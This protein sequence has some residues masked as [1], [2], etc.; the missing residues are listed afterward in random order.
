MLT[1]ALAQLS[2]GRESPREQEFGPT[3]YFM[4]C[5]VD[6]SNDFASFS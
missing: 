2:I 5:V 3:P 1:L 6:H 4:G